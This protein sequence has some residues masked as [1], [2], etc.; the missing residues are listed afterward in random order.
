MAQFI[1][2]IIWLALLCSEPIN[3]FNCYGH[4]HAAERTHDTFSN[5]I[6][7]LNV[8][9]L[10]RSIISLTDEI[11]C[12]IGNRHPF[13]SFHAV[14]FSHYLLLPLSLRVFYLYNNLFFSLCFFLFHCYTDGMNIRYTLKLLIETMTTHKKTHIMH[15]RL[16]IFHWMEHKQW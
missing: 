2:H 7:K 15:K 3:S 1:D 8:L 9:Y 12:N 16:N 14:C 13:V 11:A 10:E 5:W 6:A 4:V